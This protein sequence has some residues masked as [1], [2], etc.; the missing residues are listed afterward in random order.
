MSVFSH[1][2]N[3]RSAAEHRPRH[4]LT[5]LLLHSIHV[6]KNLNSAFLARSAGL[7]VFFGC[8]CSPLPSCAEKTNVFFVRFVRLVAKLLSLCALGYVLLADDAENVA[9]LRAEPC[10]LENGA[11]ESMLVGAPSAGSC[12]AKR[13]WRSFWRASACLCGGMRW[14]PGVRGG[15]LGMGMGRCGEVE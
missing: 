3:G 2:E 11:L 15:R 4:T 1:H 9:W 13:N 14:A 8:S 12:S 7:N 6:P 5:L 10:E